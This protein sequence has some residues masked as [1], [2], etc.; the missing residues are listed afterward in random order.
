[1]PDNLFKEVK[2]SRILIAGLLVLSIILIV[3]SCSSTKSNVVE[4]TDI[5]FPE[6]VLLSELPVLLVFHADW[7]WNPGAFRESP[8]VVLAI[9]EISG[10][11]EGRIKFCRME[12]NSNKDPVAKEFGIK[13][14]PTVVFYKNG[15]EIAREEG[16]GC[17]VEASKQTLK[18]DIE[19]LL[20]S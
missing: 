11:Y 14:I 5:N 20:V 4:V 19:E 12:V 15:V 6:E 7:H 13:W 18:S 2:L 17:T 1:M 10:E 8:P 9:K 16:S 3:C